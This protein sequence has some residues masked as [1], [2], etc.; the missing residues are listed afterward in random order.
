MDCCVV[1]KIEEPAIG[2]ELDETLICG[3]KASNDWVPLCYCFGFDESHLREEI[4]QTGTTTIPERISRLIREGLCECDV[5]NPSGNCCL[6]E[7][8]RTA[9]RL[10]KDVSFGGSAR[11][12][13]VPEINNGNYA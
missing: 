3:S 12:M 10:K 9:N 11:L 13:G 6:G 1:K 8:R 5:R 7:V 2:V 4:A